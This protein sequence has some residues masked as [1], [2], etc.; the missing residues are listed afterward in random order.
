MASAKVRIYGTEISQPTRAVM[1]MCEIASIPYDLVQIS[2]VGAR[3]RRA[4]YISGINPNGRIPAMQDVDGFVVYEAPA[5]LQYISQKYGAQHLYPTDWKT[6]AKID[7][8]MH[9]HH[10][11]ARYISTGY[12]GLIMRVDV[13][14]KTW[15]LGTDV[16]KRRSTVKKALDVIEQHR[17]GEHEYI[18]GNTLSIA[19]ILC[20]EELVQLEVWNLLDSGSNLGFDGD[21]T[22]FIRSRYPN[23]S[24]WLIKMRKLAKHDAIHAVMVKDHILKHVKNRSAAFAKEMERVKSKL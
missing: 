1:W 19:D 11:T 13:S 17:L 3:S 6:R 2:V 10:E 18:A 23:I 8:Y 4:A 20:Y 22:T 9:W 7:E 14:F 16:M 15:L 5:I 12:V 24:R 21:G